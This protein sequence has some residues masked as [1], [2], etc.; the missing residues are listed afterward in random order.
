MVLA[1]PPDAEPA[2]KRTDG[3]LVT[4]DDLRRMPFIIREDGSGTRTVMLDALGRAGLAEK[5]LRIV[6]RIEGTEPV[7]QAVKA[8]LGA[9]ILSRVAVAEEVRDGRIRVKRV[10][11]LDL[12]RRFYL[13]THARRPGSLAQSAFTDHL[14][15][16]RAPLS[17]LLEA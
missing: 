10:Q 17:T 15:A 4:L 9:S 11:N 12:G 16:A 8:G 13:V 7:R 3:P 1:L 6:A 14:R 2:D 5:D